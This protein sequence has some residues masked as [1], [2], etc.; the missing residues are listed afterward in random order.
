MSDKYMLVCDDCS[1][2]ILLGE[3]SYVVEEFESGAV[4]M[5]CEPCYHQ[6]MRAGRS[7]VHQ[8]Q[9]ETWWVGSDTP[10]YGVTRGSP[11]AHC[12]FVAAVID[13]TVDPTYNEHIVCECFDMST[14]Q[15]IARL[16]NQA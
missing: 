4:K 6:R 14:A 1:R 10:R 3:T 2:G 11:S 5:L 12:C 16:L 8:P 13:L 7:M 15:K 9:D